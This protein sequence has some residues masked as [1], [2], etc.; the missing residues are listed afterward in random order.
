MSLLLLTVVSHSRLSRHIGLCRWAMLAAPVRMMCIALPSMMGPGGDGLDCW[1]FAGVQVGVS[2]VILRRLCT[3]GKKDPVRTQAS[4]GLVACMEAPW[5]AWEGARERTWS[6][7]PACEP[8][9]WW[10]S[11]AIENAQRSIL[12]ERAHGRRMAFQEWQKVKPTCN[13]HTRVPDILQK[14]Q[15]MGY[16]TA[17][18]NTHTPHNTR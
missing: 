8:H 12:Q 9:E 14:N 4:V 15:Q 2:P 5:T 3:S 18:P 1:V 16:N 7:Q 6:K 17:E 11:P 10:V 13:A